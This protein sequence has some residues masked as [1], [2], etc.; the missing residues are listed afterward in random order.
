MDVAPSL[1]F[2]ARQVFNT[3][4]AAAARAPAGAGGAADGASCGMGA[5]GAC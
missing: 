1:L 4:L 2:R 3:I 5:G